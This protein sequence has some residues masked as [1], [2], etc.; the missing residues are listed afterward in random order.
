LPQIR[1][2]PSSRLFAVDL[3]FFRTIL[4]QKTDQVV[5]QRTLIT[6][7][8]MKKLAVKRGQ[9]YT[10]KFTTKILIK[11]KQKQNCLASPQTVPNY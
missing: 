10:K 3:L 8:K 7:Y 1:L 4:R 2:L 5:R 6:I 9:K 11:N